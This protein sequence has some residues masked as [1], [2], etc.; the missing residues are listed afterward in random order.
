MRRVAPFLT[1]LVIVVCVLGL[2]HW[3]PELVF[4]V[5]GAPRDV[6]TSPAD[7]PEGHVRLRGKVQ[8][9]TPADYQGKQRDL[10][11]IQG[12]PVAVLM[13]QDAP[14]EKPGDEV[15][16]TGRVYRAD[17]LGS[18]YAGNAWDQVARFKGIAVNQLF[19]LIDGVHPAVPWSA[20][21]WS[22]LFLVMLLFSAWRLVRVLRRTPSQP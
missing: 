13:R 2:Q 20:I 16:V 22:L 7:V 18:I 8:L 11:L 4:A 17:R 10:V 21:A 9:I 1:L 12:A 3:A 5:E 15:D 6:G 14:G 19:V